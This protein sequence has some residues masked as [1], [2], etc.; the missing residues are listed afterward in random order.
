MNLRPVFWAA[1]GLIAGILAWHRFAPSPDPSI[2]YGNVSVQGVVDSFPVPSGGPR[3]GITVRLKCDEISGNLLVRLP[4]AVDVAYG[5]KIAAAG[6]MERPAGPRNPGGPDEKL[7]LKRKGA[8]GRLTVKRR[9]DF[10]ILERGGGSAFLRR[11]FR[12]RKSLEEIIDRELPPPER[13]VA[14]LILLGGGTLDPKVRDSFAKSGTAH[15]LA[16]S[17]GH[18]AFI[19][20]IIGA[21]LTVFRLPRRAVF[22][23]TILL[24]AMYCVMAGSSPSVLRA[25]IMIGIHLAG[26]ALNRE[27]ELST[28]LSWAALCILC[29]NPM[30]LY[31]PGFQLSFLSV[32][33]LGSLD[34]TGG[35]VFFRAAA[36]SAFVWLGTMAVAAYHFQIF[37]PVSIFSNLVLFPYLGVVLA[38]GAAFLALGSVSGPA[39]GVLGG[40]LWLSVKAL[41]AMSR[42]FS[43]LPFAWFHVSPPASWE[44]AGSLLL[45]FGWAFRSGL[46][47][48]NI[49]IFTAALL[50]LNFSAWSAVFRAAPEDLR[51]TFLDVGHGDAALLEFPGG[52]TLLVDGGAGGDGGSWDRGGNV[53]GPFLRYRGIHRLDGVLATHPHYDHYGGLETVLEDFNVDRFFHNGDISREFLRAKGWKTETP[54]AR[55]SAGDRL[56]SGGG[57]DI[58]VLHPPKGEAFHKSPNERSIV[59]R[60]EFG[61]FSALFAGDAEKRA[62]RNVIQNFPGAEIRADV[63][64]VPHHGSDPGPVLDE[65]LDRVRPGIAVVSEGK[66]P[67]G[68]PSAS[69]LFRLRK[70]GART[71]QTGISG[72]VTLEAGRDGTRFRTMLK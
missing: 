1:V 35:N 42:W 45:A 12:V 29:L 69:V 56:L 63:L 17:G 4:G 43:S 14:K 41:L 2:P 34:G 8:L 53:V 13:D 55:L 21:A 62:L 71:V 59:F 30:E 66:N 10:R 58:S 67:F 3:P 6:T 47:R 7:V 46:G 16:I 48:K 61:D 37:C 68:L 72:A 11:I 15:L 52:G 49:W 51:V 36:S 28:S 18:V 26:L 65:F 27:P 23:F 32:F 57:A 64:K 70:A 60:L 25:V 24:L 33:I 40:S 50:A 22:G 39:G 31:N 19:A 38:C 20:G 5:D 54:L 9:D 44:I